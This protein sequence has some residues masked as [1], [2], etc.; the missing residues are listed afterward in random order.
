MKMCAWSDTDCVKYMHEV[1]VYIYMYVAN[2][3]LCK[4]VLNNIHP[5]FPLFKT[6]KHALSGWS[7]AFSIM[8]PLSTFISE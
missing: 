4:F 5:K 1:N 7:N 2:L 6:D 8:E 3:H